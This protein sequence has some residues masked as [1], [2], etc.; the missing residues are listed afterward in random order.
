MSVRPAR[1]LDGPE[2]AVSSVRL[3]SC[4]GTLDGLLDAGSQQSVICVTTFAEAPELKGFRRRTR[5]PWKGSSNP[6]ITEHR[7]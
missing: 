2:A 7:A 6:V 5:L 1:E 4:L 3:T